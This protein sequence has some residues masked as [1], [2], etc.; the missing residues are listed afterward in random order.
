[1]RLKC[2]EGE[3]TKIKLPIVQL[4]SEKQE[5]VGEF[6][7]GNDLQGSLSKLKATLSSLAA[8]SPP[9]PN[10][11]CEWYVSNV[12]SDDQ[13]V[14]LQLRGNKLIVLK[15]YRDG[16]KKCTAMEPSFIEFSE[17]IKSPRF[18]WLQAEVANIPNYTE[19]LK[20][21]LKGEAP[22]TS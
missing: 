11:K 2:S 5:L 7:C 15:I 8:A 3:G 18:K 9:G 16:C 6:I 20:R 21:R 1:M 22:P 14:D 17:T 19:E 4:I 13:L 12:Y 10:D